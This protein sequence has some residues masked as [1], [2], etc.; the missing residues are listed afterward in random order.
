MTSRA[1]GRLSICYL[2]PGHRLLPSAG[3]SRNVLS[4]ARAM[5]EDADV[6]VA[7]RDRRSG[8]DLAP[9]A[10]REIDP[11]PGGETARA[12]D[13]A[14]LRGVSYLDFMRYMGALRRFVKT[15]AADF[16]V[17]LEKSWLLSGRASVLYRASGVTAI[18]VENVVPALSSAGRHDVASRARM[19][20]GRWLTGRS[21]RR[22]PRVI[23]ETPALQ[24]S[25]A[26]RYGIVPARI[27]VVPLGVDRELFRPADRDEARAALG[28]PPDALLV[29]YVGVL[30][31]IHDLGPVIRGLRA[32]PSATLEVVGDGPLGPAYAELAERLDAPVR[33][34]GRV[35]HREVLHWVAAADVCV[36]PYDPAAFYRG[37]VTYSTLK[38]REYLAAGRPV[39]SVRSGSIPDLIEEGRTGFL[40][41]HDD[42]SWARALADLPD[43]NALRAMGDR[44]A[45]APVRGW[46]DVAA[47][48]LA[49]CVD[50]VREGRP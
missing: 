48:Y 40:V 36:A 24:A 35:A 14:A 19:A 49:I 46:S 4:L 17:V 23:A 6:T 41:T 31:R 13:D 21:L 27:T 20:V 9:V 47:D 50:A 8:A 28:L 16:D 5:A 29:L 45:A 2:V 10:V 7:F 11:A 12:T 43:R 1:R 39:L 37:E 22:A 42:E 32:A 18:P 30:D 25:L 15:T 33:F 38:I 3:P 26:G 44:A 34:R